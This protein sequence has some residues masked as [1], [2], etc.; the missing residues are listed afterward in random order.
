MVISTYAEK[1]FLKNPNPI[2]NRKL[3]KKKKKF[4]QTRNHRECPQTNKGTQGANIM[5]NGT[6][7]NCCPLRSGTRQV[8]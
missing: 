5:L 3:K 8:C 6:A 4:H 2:H 1:A 7:L